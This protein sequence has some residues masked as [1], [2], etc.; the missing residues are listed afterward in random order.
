[1]PIPPHIDFRDLR[2]VVAHPRD[3]D[4]DLLI[5]HLQRLGC[6]VPR[7][8]DG[9]AQGRDPEHELRRVGRGG[10][11]TFASDGDAV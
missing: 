1:M 8:R 2:M 3:H 11:V 7:L 4:G 6:R 9:V 10:G 5:R